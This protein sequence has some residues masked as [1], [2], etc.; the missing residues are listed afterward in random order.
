MAKL[1]PSNSGSASVIG[2]ETRAAG[3]NP[4]MP[5]SCLKP[6]IQKLSVLL[7]IYFALSYVR[8]FSM[9]DPSGKSDGTG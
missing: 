7:S 5:E 3:C 6:K 1:Q 9:A 8:I 2:D 4:L